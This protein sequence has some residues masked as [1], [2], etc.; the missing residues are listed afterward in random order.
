MDRFFLRCRTAL[1]LARAHHPGASRLIELLRNGATDTPEQVW[2]PR[3]ACSFVRG[4][5]FIDRS[6]PFHPNDRHAA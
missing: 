5:S 6:N 4:A 3:V 2:R 1:D